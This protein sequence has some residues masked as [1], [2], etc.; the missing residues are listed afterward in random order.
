[1]RDLLKELARTRPSTPDVD[2]ARMERDLARIVSMPR[3]S[4]EWTGAPSFRRLVPV[5]VAVLV[6]ALAVVLVPSDRSEQLATS[7]AGWHV[8]TRQTTLMAVGDPANPYVVRI[9]SDTDRWLSVE[10]QTTVRQGGGGVVPFSAGDITKWEAAGRPGKARQV[11]GNHDVR[12]GPVA[13]AVSK[14]NDTGFAVT[15][16]DRLSFDALRTLPTSQIPLQDALRTYISGFDRLPQDEARY[17][18]AL[19]AMDVL[20]MN[21]SPEQQLAAYQVLT[22]LFVRNAEKVPLPNGREGLAGVV[23]T[24]PRFQFSNV[25]TQLIIDPKTYSPLMIRDVITTPQHGLAAG[26]AISSVE[27]LAMGPTTGEPHVPAGVV[28]NGEADSPIVER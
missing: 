5:L 17:R 24:P 19:L 20:A 28:V 3:F 8:M 23:P 27:F 7:P 2:P 14:T 21:T 9:Q 26:T 18:L 10:R 1:M 16:V 11:G 6:A 4:R 15:T 12:I 13:A 25:E 22:G